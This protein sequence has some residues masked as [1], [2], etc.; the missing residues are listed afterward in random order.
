MKKILIALSTLAV[1][2]FGGDMFDANE[3]KRIGDAYRTISME[4]NNMKFYDKAQEYHKKAANIYLNE[5]AKGNIE[6]YTKLYSM[7]LSGYGVKKDIKKADEFLKKAADEGDAESQMT[8]ANN[9]ILFSDDNNKI[10]EAVS[11]LRELANRGNDKARN[12]LASM[13]SRGS[14]VEKDLNKSI[15]LYRMSA[16]QGNSSA[17][18]ILKIICEKNPSACK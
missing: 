15:K 1:V 10:E 18:K 8:Q 13:Y 3:A 11:T 6:A 17:K 16:K 14:V 7:Y 9:Y 4:T 2:A 5:S 12:Y